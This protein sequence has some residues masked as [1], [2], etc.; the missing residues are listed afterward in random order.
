[1]AF[2]AA[3]VPVFSAVS[4]VASGVMGMMS[5]RQQAAA[6]SEN[7]A[8]QAQV[9]A[10]NQII[11]NQQAEYA[12]Q[13]GQAQA[14][15]ASLEGAQRDAS[16]VASMAA[17]GVD[18]NVGS[19]VKV[20]QSNRVIGQLAALTK[21]TDAANVAYGYQSQAANYG[22]Q[23]QLDTIQSQQEAPTATTG[24]G[25]LLSGVAGAAGQGMSAFNALTPQNPPTMAGG[26]A[27]TVPAQFQWMQNT[28][29][30]SQWSN[31][32]SFTGS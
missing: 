26:S 8:Y 15:Q 9:A 21:V 27:P 30:Y 4:S 16:A 5:Q 6:A 3:A 23:S 28:N 20:Q 32:T 10:N 14:E 1:M 13:V 19:A 12:T 7:S 22:A 24:L 25:S 18:V 11:A 2:A 31:G 17:N 29:N